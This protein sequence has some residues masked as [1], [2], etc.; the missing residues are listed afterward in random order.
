MRRDA[1][2]FPRGT[3]MQTLKHWRV[4]ERPVTATELVNVRGA[5]AAE[6][7]ALELD[8]PGSAAAILAEALRINSE[9][10][11][12]CSTRRGCRP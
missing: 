5:L 2:D 8:F 4:F 7:A 9:A 1:Q 12:L 11:C 6:L 3:D 10:R